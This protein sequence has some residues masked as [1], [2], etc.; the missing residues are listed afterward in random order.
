MFGPGGHAYVYF[1]Y[2]M[3][4]M[5]NIVAS[6]KGDA[7]AVLL[8]AAEPM[9]GW[10]INLTGPGRLARG[11]RITRGLNGA[12]LTGDELF[13][14]RFGRGRPKIVTGPRVGVEYAG[15]WAAEALR[16]A[17]AES[18]AVSKPPLRAR[19]GNVKT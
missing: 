19:K 17:D 6:V 12:D 11:M 7:Q 2:G 10:E 13:V 14:A 15:E 16:F 4:D 9:D 1:I 8:R 3:H 18:A 5:F